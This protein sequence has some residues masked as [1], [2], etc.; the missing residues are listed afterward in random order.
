MPDD[1]SPPDAALPD[2]ALPDAA[3]PD[4]ALPD[5]ALPPD[6]LTCSALSLSGV[7]AATLTKTTVT[8]NG[9]GGAIASG[10]WR[11]DELR[12]QFFTGVAGTVVGL[13]DV[14]AA[15]SVSGAA[16][17]HVT[18]NITSPLASTV[19]DTAQG[20]Y[21]LSG[22]LLTITEACGGNLPLQNEEYTATATTLVVWTT[23]TV[24][25]FS[26]PAELHLVPN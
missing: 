1:A 12:Y 2:A 5:A 4:A 13:V 8:P 6:A 7:A 21:A 23:I 25:G 9:Q 24:S 20:P 18:A 17:V 26:V 11:L 15:D 10:V 14:G 3:L 19:D 16:N 22:N